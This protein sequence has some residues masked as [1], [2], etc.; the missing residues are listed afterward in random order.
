MTIKD[1]KVWGFDCETFLITNQVTPRPVCWTFYNGGPRMLM[2]DVEGEIF[3]QRLLRNGATLVAQNACFDLCVASVQSTETFR[4]INEALNENRI[5]CTKLAQILLNT[6]DPRTDGIRT[7][8]VFIQKAEDKWKVVPSTKME[9]LVWKYLQIDIGASKEGNIRTGYGDLYGTP[10][11]EW[12]HAEQEYAKNDAVYVRDVY[13]AQLEEAEKLESKIGVNVLK[14]LARQ[15][16]VEYILQMMATVIGVSIDVDKIDDAVEGCM[17]IHD[18]AMKPALDFGLLKPAKNDRGYSA[19]TSKIQDALKQASEIVGIE[20]A[21]TKTGKISANKQAM[22]QLFSAME[23][24]FSHGVDLKDKKTLDRVSRIELAEIQSALQSK[25]KSDTAWKEKRTFLDALRNAKLNPDHRLRYGYNGLMETG[26]TSSRNPNLQN[27]P[28]KGK[29]RAC[30]KPREGHIFLQADYSNA[31]LRTL[32]QTHI[33]EGRVTRLGKEYQLNPNFDPH[34]YMAIELMKM[35]GV[36]LE[37]EEGLAVLQDKEHE[38]YK[39]LKEKRQ[40]SKIA[41]FGYAG[42]LGS[43]QFVDYAKGYGTNLTMEQS[44]KLREDW[45]YVWTEMDDY[46][47]TRSELTKHSEYDDYKDY[48]QVYHF[49]STDR[50]RYLRKFT[51]ACNTPFQGIASDGAKEAIIMVWN[52]CFFDKE[53]P[54]YKCIPILFVH[55]E[56][57]LEIPFKDQE[58]ATKSAKRLQSLMEQGMRKHTPDV[59]A[60]AEPC[61][62]YEWTKDAESYYEN[63]LLSIYEGQ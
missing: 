41:N 31:E 51:I 13:F 33:N 7:G 19:V 10:V 2:D 29:A 56:L 18:E 9:G 46:F 63:G 43:E 26:R 28:R 16:H 61:L 4:L 40:L 49:R 35:E 15:T 39:S 36:H 58:S 50:V 23:T 44:E 38:L 53:S 11:E 34:L 6:A 62:T 8:N 54:L 52:E 3:L 25:L 60:V 37:Y 12:S 17:E 57:V 55:D 24:V 47:R 21:T 48:N 1:K 20:L 45:L 30:I 27:I 22:E 42:G 5:F 32:A 59:P 14:D